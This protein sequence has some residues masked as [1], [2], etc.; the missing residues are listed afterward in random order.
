MQVQQAKPKEVWIKILAKGIVTIP[1]EFR[2]KLGLREGGVAKARVVGKQLIIESHEAVNYR[3]YSKEEIEGMAE[4]T[5]KFWSKD[6]HMALAKAIK[7]VQEKLAGMPHYHPEL[8]D[9]ELLY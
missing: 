6:A 3:I 4:K 9:D 1:K 5:K 2:K 7:R 8:T